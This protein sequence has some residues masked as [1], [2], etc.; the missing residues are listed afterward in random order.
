M[1][2]LSFFQTLSKSPLSYQ[3]HHKEENDRIISHIRK[4]GGYV[5]ENV[6]FY[7][8]KMDL[9][10]AFLYHIGDNCTIT[11]C[12]I[13][14]HDASMLKAVGATKIGKIFIGDNVFI[15]AESIIL[16]NMKIGNNVIIGAGCVVAKD[17]PDNS[18]VAGN[19]AIIVSTYDKFVEK[20][21]EY[22]KNSVTIKKGTTP[23]KKLH[24]AILE[25][26][27]TYII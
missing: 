7:D 19:P 12:R 10:N 5:G 14:N 26:G 2:F 27:F 4:N 6:D 9:T 8:V 11:N 22:I 1:K 18:V 16:P 23:P 13:L 20:H 15:G 3:E 21:K 24:E 25:R 17:I